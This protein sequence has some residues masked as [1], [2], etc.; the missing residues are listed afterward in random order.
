[1]HRPHVQSI[2]ASLD[3]LHRMQSHL[4]HDTIMHVSTQPDEWFGV[5]GLLQYGAGLPAVHM[6]R[7]AACVPAIATS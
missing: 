3:M 4:L 7:E 6:I 2:H 1:M 5:S